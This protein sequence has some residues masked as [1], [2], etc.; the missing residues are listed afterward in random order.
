METLI[1]I[2]N[3]TWCHSVSRFY[4]IFIWS[5]TCFG[6]HTAHHQELKTALAPSGF[7]YV[8]GCWTVIAGHWQCPATTHPAAFHIC[9]TRGYQCSFRLLMMGGVSPET[10]WASCKYEIK[11]WYTVASCWIFY[12]NYTMMH[13]FTN[14]KFMETLRSFAV[15]GTTYP[16]TVSHPRT[17][18]R[19]ATL[20]R[21]LKML[22]MWSY[23]LSLPA[24]WLKLK[25][26]CLFTVS[27][28]FVCICCMSES[29]S[30]AWC[31]CK[32]PVNDFHTSTQ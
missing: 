7:A 15:L 22:L 12:T 23:W 8:E 3:P 27:H 4:F 32:K 21:K 13:G 14:I 1:R 6:W 28:N 2:E 29:S 17:H 5:S 25:P 19:S 9:K 30:S 26:Q 20:L 24:T 31:Y 18:E 10:C 16:D 11:F